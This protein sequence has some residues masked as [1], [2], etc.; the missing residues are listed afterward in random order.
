MCDPS[1]A[2]ISRTTEIL[3]LQVKEGMAINLR[4]RD[5]SVDHCPAVKIG[6]IHLHRV[7]EITGRHMEEHIIHLRKEVS[8]L[9]DL[10]DDTEPHIE[11]NVP[12][13]EVRLPQQLCVPRIDV[14]T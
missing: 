7:F 1:R 12:N 3:A 6:P 9:F 8:I 11:Y 14:K 13:D 2:E 10:L 5:E 4:P